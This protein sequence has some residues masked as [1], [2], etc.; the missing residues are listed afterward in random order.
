MGG[1][2]ASSVCPSVLS[3]SICL[4]LQKHCHATQ[5]PETC[6]DHSVPGHLGKDKQRVRRKGTEALKEEQRAWRARVGVR[7]CDHKMAD[8]MM[9]GP[10]R[11]ANKILQQATGRA[12]C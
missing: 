8:Y 11:E 5:A 4:R 7:G 2:R 10:G 12:N 9:S 6:A 1:G 3:Q